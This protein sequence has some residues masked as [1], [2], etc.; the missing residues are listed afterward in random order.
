MIPDEIQ[1]GHYG[2]GAFFP[3][4][5]LDPAT[6]WQSQAPGNIPV[7]CTDDTGGLLA[8]RWCAPE[9]AGA[10]APGSL[11]EVLATAPPVHELHDT[12]CLQ[13]FHRALPQ[14]LHLIALT[15]TSVIGPW[16]RRPGQHVAAIHPTRTPP[17]GVPR[18]A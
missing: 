9:S 1:T 14:H 17:V 4:V 5:V 6:H 3:L 13:A 2:I 16:S 18:A 11:A 8:V 12:E 10:Q 7:R 15:A